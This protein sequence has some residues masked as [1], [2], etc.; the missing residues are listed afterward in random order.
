MVLSFFQQTRHDCRIERIYTKGRQNKTDCFKNDGF[1]S[2]RNIVF[3]AMG[4]FCHFC[5]C[6]E[7][8]PPLTEENLRRGKRKKSSVNSEKIEYKKRTPLFL[9]CGSVSDADCRIETVTLNNISENKCSL[10]EYQLLEEV[11]K[12]SFGYV[13]WDI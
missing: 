4:Y 5:Q 9:K 1:Y 10:T 3:E 11:K 13:Q 12:F 2:L 7:L 6:Q 8:P